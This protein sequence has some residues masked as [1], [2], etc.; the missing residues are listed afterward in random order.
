MPLTRSA[1]RSR[2]AGCVRSTARAP[3]SRW[4]GIRPVAADAGRTRSVRGLDPAGPASCCG[5]CSTPGIRHIVARH[6]RQRD[7]RWRAR[8]PRRRSGRRCGPTTLACSSISA[9]STRGSPTSSCRI[10]CDVS[11][12]LARRAR[13]GGHLRAAEGRDAG[14]RA[15]LWTPPRA[16]GGRARGRDRATR[17]R[18]PGRR[19]GRWDR[20]SG[21]CPSGSGSAR[22][23][24]VPG[25]RPRDGGDR[26]RDRLADADLVITG[27]GR[28]DAQTAFGKTALGVARRARDV[29]VRASRSAVAS[30]PRE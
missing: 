5:P 26:L 29:G 30:S 7:H 14:G 28:I 1:G 9:G 11:N 4:R 18:D 12:P 22:S 13:C 3:S 21:C 20:P 19:G 27:E 23:S 2:R 10:A 17:A 8:D 6:R 15:G 24:C 16:L 25:R